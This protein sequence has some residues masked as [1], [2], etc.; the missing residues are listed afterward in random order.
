MPTLISSPARIPAAG[1][2]SKE[3][4]EFVGRL[5]TGTGKI[6]VAIMNSPAGWREPPQQPAFDEY[7]VV[8]EGEVHVEAGEGKLVVRAGQA[9]HARSGEQVRY[10]T[11]CGAR[12]VSVCVP[13]FSPETV[14]RALH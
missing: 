3:I 10:S 4:L 5:A 1:H 13:A 7:T 6:S 2:P 14:Q 9:V 12:Y 8:L 11:P